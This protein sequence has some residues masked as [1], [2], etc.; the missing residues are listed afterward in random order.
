M[1]INYEHTPQQK[2]DIEWS[3]TVLAVL[4][5]PMGIIVYSIVAWLF[6]MTKQAGWDST[7]FGPYFVIMAAFAGVAA[8]IV[9]LY[10]YRKFCSLEEF[11]TLKHFN[12][13][14]NVLLILAFFYGY[15]SFS[16]YFSKWYGF[17]EFNAE[18]IEKLFD[19]SGYGAWFFYANFVAILLPMIILGIPKWRSINNVLISAIIILTGV[20]IKCYLIIIPT[21]ESQHMPIQDARPEWVSYSPSLVEIAL[22]LWGFSMF[23][24]LM[25]LVAKFVTIIPSSTEPGGYE[26]SHD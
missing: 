25:T 3:Q 12:I 2:K 4:V 22:T 1:A 6:G 10:A 11:I 15:L 23:A 24:L 17:A 21:L 16:E 9:V 20:W 7:I 8:L 26:T 19:F 18:L 14:A 5:I 13:G